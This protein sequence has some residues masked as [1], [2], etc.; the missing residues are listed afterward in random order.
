MQS[1]LNDKDEKFLTIVNDCAFKI[2][3]Y[4]NAIRAANVYLKKNSTAHFYLSL[5]TVINN[6]CC[7]QLRHFEDTELKKKRRDIHK[8][9]DNNKT[10]AERNSF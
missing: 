3:N 6:H 2:T 4:N 9:N 7:P 10:T 5:N 1:E 8:E